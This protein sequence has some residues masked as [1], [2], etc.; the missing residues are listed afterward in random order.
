[1]STQQTLVPPLDAVLR[2]LEDERVTIRKKASEDLGCLLADSAVVAT[3]NR[4]PASGVLSWTRD[5]IQCCREIEGIDMRFLNCGVP[6]DGEDRQYS[7]GSPHQ[8]SEIWDL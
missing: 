2:N 1:M 3:L 6:R 7:T 5:A 4:A 8:S